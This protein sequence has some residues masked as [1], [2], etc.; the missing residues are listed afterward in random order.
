MAV[1]V[2]T[3]GYSCPIPVVMVQK[4]VKATSPAELDVLIDTK[5]AVEN[6]TRFAETKGYRVSVKEE[7]GEWRLTLTK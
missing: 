6:V 4:E 1:T 2:D 3:R 5:V 7:N